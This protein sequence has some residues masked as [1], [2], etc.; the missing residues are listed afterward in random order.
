LLLLLGLLRKTGKTH[1]S[2]DAQAAVEPVLLL[3]LLQAVCMCTA[4]SSPGGAERDTLTSASRS[5]TRSSVM[6]CF[7]VATT[8]ANLSSSTQLLSSKRAITPSQGDV[9]KHLQAN[10]AVGVTESNQHAACGELAPAPYAGS[11]CIRLR[12]CWPTVF[13]LQV[14][15]AGNRR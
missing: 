12:V 2:V 11:N 8:N 3:L 14:I 15:G 4:A 1:A 5:W 7:W 6:C 13:V 10:Q 9:G